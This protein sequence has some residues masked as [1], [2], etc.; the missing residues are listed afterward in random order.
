MIHDA[1]PGGYV[2]IERANRIDVLCTA[3]I[4]LASISDTSKSLHR[5]ARLHAQRCKPVRVYKERAIESDKKDGFARFEE[6]NT[7]K[8]PIIATH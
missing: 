2:R 4:E 6:P 5:S 1:Y 8:C 3:I 7:S